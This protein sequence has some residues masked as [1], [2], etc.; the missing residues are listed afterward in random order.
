MDAV[1]RYKATA[2]DQIISIPVDTYRDMVRENERL[3]ILRSLLAN[4]AY[5]TDFTTLAKAV[6]GVEEGKDNA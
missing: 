3:F 5:T 1:N 6:L 4:Y 2:E